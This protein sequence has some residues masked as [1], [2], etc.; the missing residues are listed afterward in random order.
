MTGPRELLDIIHRINWNR[1]FI[2]SNA[3]QGHYWKH[4]NTGLQLECEKEQ[5]FVYSL[6]MKTQSIRSTKPILILILVTHLNIRLKF[7]KNHIITVI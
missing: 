7:K 1:I 5:H 2:R 6:N 3:M 4:M